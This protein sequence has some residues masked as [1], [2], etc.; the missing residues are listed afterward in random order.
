[1]VAPTLTTSAGNTNFVEGDNT[2]SLRYVVDPGITIA[3]A[4]STSFASATVS[5]TS[6]YQSGVDSLVL[7]LD[8]SMG[9]ITRS[10]V[11]STGVMTLSSAGATAT[12]EQWQAALRQIA[13]NNSSQTPTGG[14]RTIG[15]ILNDGVNSSAV[16]SK[17]V[18]VSAVNDSASLGVGRTITDLGGSESAQAVTVLPDGKIL[19]AGS[20]RNTA[21]GVYTFAEARYNIDGSLDS[22]FGVAG[23][24]TSEFVNGPQGSAIFNTVMGSDG[25]A[26]ALGYIVNDSSTTVADTRWALARYNADGTLDTSFDADGKQTYDLRDYA[27]LN[28]AATQSDGKILVTGD[29]ATNP[30]WYGDT[31][32]LRLN[33][34]G[35]VDTSFGTSGLVTLSFGTDSAGY[36][37]LPLPNDKILV[38]CGIGAGVNGNLGL[39]RLNSNGA[40]D[41]SFDTDGIVT[42]SLGASYA[43]FGLDAQQQT[44]QKIVVLASAY[45][46]LTSGTDAFL[47]RYNADGSLDASFDSDGK[48][49]VN[50]MAP[51]QITLQPD[52]RILLT[53]SFQGN[54]AVARY[55]SD[56]GVDATFGTAGR[57]ITDFGTSGD[58][59][60]TLAIDAVGKM[61]VAGSSNGNFALARYNSDGSLDTSFVGQPQ[62]TLG[63]YV[64]LDSRATLADPE[65][66]V[67]GYGGSTLTLER[68]GGPN[69]NDLF[70]AK[71]GGNLGTLTEGG[72][73]T[74]GGVAIGTVV[75]N[76]GGTL[77]LSFTSSLAGTAVV[78]A[79]QNFVNSAMRQLAYGN[80]VD[81]VGTTVHIDWKFS[82]GNTGAQGPGGAQTSVASSTITISADNGIVVTGT[83]GD[84]ALTGGTGNDYL[85]GGLGNDT[86]TGNTGSDLFG[87]WKTAG[88]LSL[89]T[90]TDFT[91]GAGGDSIAVPSSRFSNYTSGSNPFTSGHLRLTQ[92]GTDTLVEVDADGAVGPAAYQTM[93]ILSNV[94]KANLVASNFNGTD[95]N[96]NLGTDLAD[97]LTGTSGNDQINGG[98][99]DDIVG[100]LAGND[101]L[102]GGAGHDSLNGGAGNDLLFGNEGNDSIS[103]GAGFDSLYGGGG[104]DT[105][106]G[107]LD[108]DAAYYSDATGPVTV[109]L[110]TGAASGSG[111]GADT[112]ISIEHVYG[113]QFNDT[114]IGGA[115]N[116]NLYGQGGNDS[117]TGGAGYDT[118]S[119]GAGNDTL[120]GGADSDTVNYSDA[121]GPVTVN[122]ALGTASGA[123]IGADTLISIENVYGSQYADILMGGANNDNLS[124]GL[125][126]DTLTGGAGSDNFQ[127]RNSSND[128][129]VDT[130]TDFVAGKGGK[131]SAAGDMLSIPTWMFTNYTSG[132]NPF[133]SGHARLTQQGVD[134]L[135]EFDMDGPSGPGSFQT[136]AILSNVNKSALLANNL[137]SYDPNAIVGTAA[138]DS[139]TGTA[140]ND[141]IDGA[142]GN[143]TISGLAGNDTLDGGL[144]DDSIDG[145]AGT[146]TAVYSSSK[147]ADWSIVA[148]PDG[149]FELTQKTTGEKDTL[150]NIEYLQ[151]QDGSKAL[152][153]S[154]WASN[155]AKG[156]NSI[157]GTDYADTINADALAGANAVSYRDLINGGAGNDT[158]H[159]GK[160]GDQISGGSGD[161]LI[162]GGEDTTLAR[163][164]PALTDTWSVQNQAQYSGP[165]ARYEILEKTD[166]STPP[167]TGTSGSTYYTVKDLRPGSPDGTDTVYKLDGLFFSDKFVR[168]TPEFGFNRMTTMVSGQSQTQLLGLFATGTDFADVI[169][170]LPDN[171]PTGT[172]DFSG[173]DNLKGNAGNDTLYGGAGADTLRGDTGNDRLDGGANRASNSTSTWDPNGSNGVDVAEFSGKTVRYAITF[174]DAGGTTVGAYDPAGTVVVTDSKTSGGDGQDTLSNIEV[175]RFADGEINLAVVS[176]PMSIGQWNG[177]TLTYSAAMNWKGTDWNDSINTGNTAANVQAGA[178]NDSITGGSAADTIDGGAGND[179]IDGGAGTDM[180]RFDA[181]QSRFTITKNSDVS[182]TVADKL[183]AEFGGLGTDTLSNIENLQFND[184]NKVLQVNFQA[185]PN[186]NS[187]NNIHGTEFADTIDADTL[188]GNSPATSTDWIQPGAGNDVVYAGAGGDNI[189]DGV[190]NDFYDGGSNGNNQDVV[191]FNG[192]QKRYVVDVLDYAT[193]PADIQALISA[194]YAGNL[195][196]SVIRVTDKLPDGDG[197]N[198]LIN[199][200][201]IQF[202]DGSVNLGVNVYQTSDAV[203]GMNNYSGGIL[204]DLIDARGHDVPSVDNGFATNRDWIN[205][206][207]GNDTLY[208]GDGGDQLQGDK[209]NDVIDGGANGS[210]GNVWDNI[211]RA[212]YSNSINR[213][214]I[215]FFSK[216][217][218]GTGQYNDMGLTTAGS[219]DYA[220]AS[221]YSA[222]GLIVVT[223]RYS[224]AM[225][226]DGRDVLR[227]IE[228]LQFS[229]AGETL[230]VQYNDYTSTQTVW[231]L[232]PLATGVTGG[233]A[234]GGVSS[235]TWGNITTT[236]TTRSAWGTRFGD[237]ITGS[238]TAKNNLQGNAGNDL[239]TGGNLRDDLTG[240]AGNDTIDGG[241][242][243]AVDPARPWDTWDNYDVARFDAPRAQFDVQ[244]LSDSGGHVYYTVTHLIPAA[245]GGLGTDTAF[246]V[247]RLQF[248]DKD[249]PLLVQ[250]N[251][252]GGT[253]SSNAWYGGTDFAD[254]ITGTDANNSFKGGAGNDTIVAGA[255]N[256]FI[257]GGAGND[258]IDG[259][260]GTDIAQYSDSYAR[261]ALTVNGSIITVSDSLAAAYG[262]DG[263]DTLRNVE[264]IQFSDGS[265]AGGIFNSYNIGVT[266]QTVTGTSNNDNLTGGLGKDTFLAGAGDDF[267]QGGPGDDSVDG[268][269]DTSTNGSNFWS[270][271]DIL[272]YGDAPRSR[273]DITDLGVISG[274]HRYRVVDLASIKNIQFSS[275]HLSDITPANVNVGIGFGVDTIT[276]V[277]QLQFSDT[278]LALAPREFQNYITVNNTQTPTGKN[279]IG[280][281]AADVLTSTTAY[282]DYFQGNGGND[283]IDGGV[284]AIPPG[285]NSWDYTDTVR[286]DGGRARY[287]VTG[288]MVRKDSNGAYAIVDPALA[289]ATDSFAIQVKDLLPDAAGGNGTDLLL[290]VDRLQFSDTWV[291]VKP[292]LYYYDAPAVAPVAGV[293]PK[294]LS[295]SGTDFADAI[296]GTAYNDWISG[297]AGDDTLVGG[298]GGDDLEGGA[299]NDLLIGATNAVADANGYVRTDTARYN[300]PFERFEIGSITYQGQAALQVRDL[301][302]AQDGNSLGTDVLVGVESL[303]FNNR[304]VDVGVRRWA[305]NDGQGQTNASAEGT[306]FNDVIYG[307]LN[308]DGT[309]AAAGQRD[310]IRGNVGND[311]LIGLGGGDNLQGGEGNDVID[312]GANGTTGNAWQDQD[313]AQ[314]S[315]NSSRYLVQTVS[316]GTD[317]SGVSHISVGNSE[318]ANFRADTANSLRIDS[319]V[320]AATATVLQNA[321]ENLT[322]ASDHSS[323]YLVTDS[324]SGDLG[325]DGTDLVFN[326][327]TLWFANGPLEVEIRVNV[328]DWNSDGTLDWVNVTGTSNADTVDM[329]KLVALSGKTE[330][331]LTATRIDVDLRDGNDV[332]IGGSGGDSVRTGLGNDYV[333]GGA[334]SG[335]DQWGNSTRDEVR[336][337]GTFGRYNLI[338]VTL[339]NSSG[340]W[341]LSSTALGLAGASTTLAILPTAL[342][343]LALADLNSAITTVIDHA[344]SQT[345]VTGWLVADRLPAAFQGG[346]VDALVNVE[347]LSFSD[348][349]L[350]L[351]MQIYY[352]R[353]TT[354]PNSAI[355]S[356]YVDG[357]QGAD[358]IGAP[359][360][361]YDYAG[362]DNLRGNEG[363]DSIAGG[364]GG[365]WISGGSGNDS[366]DGGTNGVDAA[367][368]ARIDVAQYG[369]EFARYTITANSNGTVTV[370]DSQV[371]GDGTDTL[372]NVEAV[373][374]SD[375]YLRLGVDTWVNKNATTGKV[376]DVQLNGSMLDD[377]INVS[378]DSYQGVRHVLRGNEGNDTLTGGSGPDEF[379]GG[380]GDDSI[381]GGANGTDTW[382]NPGFDVA[383]YQ[384]AY[385]RYTIEYSTDEGLTWVSSNAGGAGVLV[386][387][388]D[389]FSAADGGTGVD[390]LSGIEALSFFDR[391]VMLQATTTVQDLN[392]DGRPDNSDITGTE[393]ADTLTGGVTN[394]HIKGGAGADS[395]SGGAG[396]DILNGGAGNDTL[397]GG[398]NGTDQ[399]GKPL[400][401]VAEYVG[402]ASH[403]TVATS[404]NSFTVTNSPGTEGEGTDTLTNIEGLQFSD[405]FVS[406]VQV[407]NALDLNKDG[408]I[409]LIDIRGLDLASAGDTIAP[410]SGN[411][412]IAHRIAGGDGNDTLTGGTANDVFIGGA[413]NDSINGAGGTDRAVFSGNYSDYTVTDIG[414]GMV[415]VQHKNNGADGTDTLSNIEELAFN[416]KVIKLGTASITIKEVDSDGNQKIDTA[417]ITGTDGADAIDRSAST[418]INFIDSGAGNDS[419]TGGSGADTF[420]PGAGSDTV[421]GGANDGLDGAGNPNMDR[422]VLSGAKAAYTI[423]TLQSAS[424]SVT[425]V[426]EV[427]D[428]VSVTVG[429][430]TVSYTATGTD[431]AVLRNGLLGLINAL[432]P[433]LSVN[434]TLSDTSIVVTTTDGLSA[435]S[436]VATNG[437]HTVSGTFAV[438]VANQTGTT[439]SISATDGV[440]LAAGMHLRYVVDMNGDGDTLDAG[441]ISELFSITGATKTV[442]E[443]V[444]DNWALTLG[445]QLG[446]SPATG[447]AVSVTADN[448]DTG[449][450]AGTV[451][452]D[453]WVT[454]SSGGETDT[455][456]GVEQL[457]FSDGVTDLSFKTGQ[458]AS[459]DIVAGLIMVNQIQGTD[460]ADILRSTSANEVLTGG[461]G[462]DHFVFADGSGAD[463]IRDFVAGATGDSITLVLGASDSDGLNGSG[464]NSATLALGR[465][466]QQGSD[467][468]IDLGAGNSVRL[469][470]VLVENLVAANFEV[471]NTF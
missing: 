216:V 229:D 26:I 245:L 350:P 251:Q 465:A 23:I 169:G 381:V 252:Y 192:A 205:G 19:V 4:D 351:N 60:Y 239:I 31:A 222:D 138:A 145:G 296:S 15:F 124:G 291:N 155:D 100:G 400:I 152:T 177:S 46:A 108:T 279:Y 37:V 309:T 376:N 219:K 258:S 179:L 346:G 471:T 413:G 300:A 373:S 5:I 263:T 333:D 242:N 185:G 186:G 440:T 226:G 466:S 464:V 59:A 326:V 306:V 435:V 28:H 29:Q 270:N 65:M 395:I 364:A 441:D 372:T 419:L 165:A 329:A 313:Q 274:T 129:S 54:F 106:D 387:V 240:G 412:A 63:G 43:R 447:A 390:I 246:N 191:Q 328:N 330:A 53:G 424:F 107:G 415:T 202:T 248:S 396:G 234:G 332:Y 453:R 161:D 339:A 76:S 438:N 86:L 141:S 367:G 414:S 38:V 199:I 36:R 79:D 384:G 144:G 374:F 193:A 178:G 142:A 90:V 444:T 298:A 352:Q 462:V 244:K 377:T 104:N 81:P 189:Q 148:N 173:S 388:T 114:L 3:D 366:I 208:G 17:T 55:N 294:A 420:T 321:Y 375:R 455:L 327:E 162:D 255:G 458:K 131:G 2:V 277:E 147:L 56:G 392:G 188:A 151:F 94:S 418:L 200:E 348:K 303:S 247:E 194:K 358:T 448:I 10:W 118:L 310:Q 469:I 117:L 425:G 12:L 363:N 335:T 110:T 405:R 231:G 123:G 256:D 180:V 338:D 436:A 70:V 254:N 196:S 437:T 360:P 369:G 292:S 233:D 30:V 168:L 281:F 334:N 187:T 344:A 6:G 174:K 166:D 122:L 451:G 456:R 120:D 89:D 154:F 259:G 449:L 212:V 49:A 97:S 34:D 282:G 416:D 271:G 45:N 280:T 87:F 181:A 261:Y 99:G 143:D 125:G 269:T 319:S 399:Q 128:T 257:S 84:D 275:G 9:N 41:T 33:V 317:G 75:S 427:G 135:I 235:D 428:V 96:A 40:L 299:G 201:R 153:A 342:S 71:P 359:N 290:N 78:G 72:N 21:T 288:V 35:S 305:W 389:S 273:F 318:V 431:I 308:T 66:N 139:M 62:S 403:Y 213:Y 1:M 74:V 221:Y 73:L 22:T 268:G 116:D 171:P 50:G 182:F 446:A 423:H 426:V 404:G 27:N 176:S 368:N 119:G 380:A 211:D 421:V 361:T 101:T 411:G 325:G 170:V 217:A 314:F 443:G 14:D 286:Y 113:S 320:A 102:Y 264:T 468:L 58:T 301:L 409:D 357:T 439:F 111:V 393:N 183:T 293:Q 228:Q 227:N 24:R 167:V 311:V 356:A 209:G 136:A 126:N 164:N 93:V 220:A 283:T 18:N 407:S 304:W 450:A 51:K 223:D 430:S 232:L 336:F 398:V 197:I 44:D 457:V 160:S 150:R 172:Y 20:S 243:P 121:T 112:L 347:A 7:N 184:G 401:D 417:Y 355:V 463:E 48:L 315:G 69:T 105:L 190:G 82:D 370:S 354:A 371:D 432:S 278:M 445:S 470:G 57:L 249:M 422:V 236:V 52:G 386:R 225:G 459:F 349:W 25:K 238:L 337:D 230:A 285:A 379:E 130:I 88:D 434:A 134:T 206:G 408:A 127:L 215:Q 442:A 61:V 32:V 98:G 287:E 237:L 218:A 91:A 394:D 253:G 297:G 146:D 175:L 391:F 340:N 362:N 331:Q 64:L 163:L 92:S 452:Y 267:I 133:A 289:A 137:S 77:K 324:L 460:L 156:M 397:D 276:N 157:N 250:V 345:S 68:A 284:E 140:G 402:P 343:T 159:A 109:D 265:W 103:G 295:A 385:A 323:G 307:D 195:P 158:I 11:A 115:G 312:G 316:I 42:T 382:G 429:S 406:L 410:A 132:A 47:L 266:D 461:A 207:V 198:Y 224:D 214:D 210:S 204:G 302:P 341:T 353:A 241:A 83:S 39:V 378:A 13:F 95:P 272:N 67:I 262:G 365:D 16:V 260:G 8:A 203:N 80:T 454:V 149:S 85:T 322:L 383:R 433:A 467:V